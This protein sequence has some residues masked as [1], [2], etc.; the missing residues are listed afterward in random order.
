[1]GYSI[2]FTGE[3]IEYILVFRTSWNEHERICPKEN[4]VT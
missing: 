4:D 3:L 2:E 1:M